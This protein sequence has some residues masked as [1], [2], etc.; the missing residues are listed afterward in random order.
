MV[1]AKVSRSNKTPIIERIFK[2]LW[3]PDEKR[4]ERSVVT[5]V[6]IIEAINEYTRDTDRKVSAGNPANFYK[7]LTRR[8]ASANAW[9][10]AFVFDQGYTAIQV[11]GDG[12]CF[13]F[14]RIPAGQSKAFIPAVEPPSPDC[15][16]HS[17]S[18]VPMPLPVRA[19]ARAD[20]SSLLQLAVR[21]RVIET[22]ISLFS[23]KREI[24]RQ[25]D[26]L[27]NA[28][29]LRFSE[30]DAI[31]LAIE[32]PDLGKYR[33]FLITCEA[34]ASGEDVTVEQLVR[35]VQ[36][37]LEAMPDQ[38]SVV[39]MVI[40]S[41]GHSNLHVVEFQEVS[42]AQAPAI[43]E[44]VKLSEAVFELRPPLPGFS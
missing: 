19:L 24:I 16:R 26:H 10:P 33:Q 21:L 15:P 44:L 6:D 2:K 12:Q 36:G 7:D 42:R 4:L 3:I 11:T 8:V 23:P 29:K 35:Q 9:W 34:K 17:I 43:T 38:H 27:Q 13:E 37:I 1:S 32:E 28:V 31:F 20:E 18:T 14:I 5:F 25:I 39:P 30:I 22:H 40:R 41:L